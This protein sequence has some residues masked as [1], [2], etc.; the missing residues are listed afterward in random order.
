MKKQLL[1]FI[2]PEKFEADY[3][4]LLGK[5]VK[6]VKSVEIYSSQINTGFNEAPNGSVFDDPDL[7]ETIVPVAPIV[8]EANIEP[9]IDEIAPIDVSSQEAIKE[10][11]ETAKIEEIPLI[12]EIDTSKITSI[13][14]DEPETSEAVETPEN[15]E[16]IQEIAPVSE[17]IIEQNISDT[18][19][20]I[21]DEDCNEIMPFET[22]DGEP[23]EAIEQ[24]TEEK[25]TSEQ[26]SIIEENIEEIKAPA[27]I[28]TLSEREKEE[29]K[30]TP[31][32]F[33]KSYENQKILEEIPEEVAQSET[34]NEQ[35]VQ[36][37][38]LGQPLEGSSEIPQKTDEEINQDTNA[39][40]EKIII[41]KKTFVPPSN[42]QLKKLK[43]RTKKVKSN[44]IVL[45]LAILSIGFSALF[46][47]ISLLSPLGRPFDSITD[48]KPYWCVIALISVGLWAF[49]KKWPYVIIS[50]L[51]L[52]L[53]FLGLYNNLGAAPTGGKNSIAK[54]GFANADNSSKNLSNI[55]AKADKNGTQ[56]LIVSAA[57]NLIS[58]PPAGW[59]IAQEA[60]TNDISR[61]LVLS[62][63]NWRV[64]TLPGE[65]TM[66][67][68]G[69]DSLTIIAINPPKGKR[70]RAANADRESIINRA[71]A[72]SGTQETPIIAFGDLDASPWHKDITE[73]TTNGALTR[74]N[75]GLIGATR[76]S[77][78][79]GIAYDHVFFRDVN[80]K[81]CKID[82]IIGKASPIWIDVT[83]KK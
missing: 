72:R 42:K 45:F 8:P 49:I 12:Q 22:L 16:Q 78:G 1:K 57:N 14:F 50:A 82:G 18:D 37:E 77:M 54:I 33:V 36:E 38:V 24:L 2:A 30:D 70:N 46:A 65:P 13:N 59:T 28:K 32:P 74:L 56:L 5:S 6:S 3:D 7:D 48:F 40:K 81:S 69:E 47:L 10:F 52:I 64:I 21:R 9:I 79:L 35:M 41:H 66:A 63:T 68:N 55:I 29:P 67:R 20:T 34:I 51:L 4:P 60:N 23:N 62:K 75:C 39:S 15:I 31:E 61:L 73:F 26:Q 17:E 83:A 11:V 53:N 71:A 76:Q 80:I 43:K 25:I 27:F 58:M 44:E 19:L